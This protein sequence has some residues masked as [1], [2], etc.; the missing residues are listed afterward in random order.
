MTSTN[1]AHSLVSSSL[2]P[3]AGTCAAPAL[4]RTIFFGLVF[5]TTF[6]GVNMMFEILRANGMT[7]IETAILVLFAVTFGWITVAF[8]TAMSGFVLRLLKL[9][10]LSLCRLPP[11][12]QLLSVPITTRTAVVMPVY[13]EN[14]VQVL[15]GLEATF[16]SL[17]N[18]GDLTPFDFF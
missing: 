7:G 5:L 3:L 9:D 8:W 1:S 4:R 6:A 18:A 12:Q 15:A 2:R 17:R 10:P 13:N 16:R 11:R 14:P